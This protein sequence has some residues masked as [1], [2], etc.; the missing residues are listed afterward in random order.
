[1]PD[2]K[3]AIQISIG[4]LLT[5]RG[6]YEQAL[7]QLN[8]AL[9]S[10]AK[11]EDERLARLCR[12]GLARLDFER[13]NYASVL[14]QTD[15]I[16]K[17]LPESG[18][19]REDFHTTAMRALSYL[20]LGDELQAWQEAARLEQL[21]QGKEGWF[22]GR[23]EGDAVRIRVIDLDSDLWLAGMVAQHG[24]GETAEDPYGEGYLQY[25][26][27]CVLARLKPAEAREAVSRAV[28]LFSQLDAAPMLNRA[29]QLGKELETAESEAEDQRE[30]VDGGWGRS[31]VR[32]SAR[33][34][35]DRR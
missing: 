6:K 24:I 5:L 15:E 26:R 8:S 17:S 2:R 21:Y 19:W 22:A 28:E 23:A 20:E 13:G 34:V 32:G 12:T 9:K 3:A 14:E 25:H 29:R 27:A 16:R 35:S 33:R 11:L 7:G 1:M 31:V 4:E 18:A 10:A 30:V